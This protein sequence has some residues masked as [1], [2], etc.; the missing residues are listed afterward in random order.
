MPDAPSKENVPSFGLNL[1]LDVAKYSIPWS[2]SGMP[3]GPGKK[4]RYGLLH[5]RKFVQ[6]EEMMALSWRGASNT[7]GFLFR[8]NDYN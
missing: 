3:K 2:K 8:I 5:R 6:G 4:Q 1:L 7:L